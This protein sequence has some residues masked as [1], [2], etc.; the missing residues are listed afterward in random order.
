MRRGS[1]TNTSYEVQNAGGDDGESVEMYG[2]SVSGTGKTGR[3]NQEPIFNDRPGAPMSRIPSTL[4][5][6]DGTAHS[7]PGGLWMR[8]S[9]SGQ[10]AS[11]G[12]IADDGDGDRLTYKLVEWEHSDAA[13]A[14]A[15]LFDYQ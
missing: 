12:F 14:E 3:G 10:I 11:E 9:R 1:K 8:T 6:V 15:S 4:S 7:P 5:K 2:W 13:R